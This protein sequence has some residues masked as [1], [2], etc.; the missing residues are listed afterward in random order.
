MFYFSDLI[1]V[2]RKGHAIMKLKAFNSTSLRLGEQLYH[3]LTG[4]VTIVDSD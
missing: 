1:F 2:L 4:A 3:K